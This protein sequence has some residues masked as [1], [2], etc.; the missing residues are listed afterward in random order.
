[1]KSV[2]TI[3]FNFY[4]GSA[5]VYNNEIHVLGGS[6]SAKVHYKWDGSSWVEVGTLPVNHYGVA[7]AVVYN[8]LCVNSRTAQ[9]NVLNH[10][11]IASINSFYYNCY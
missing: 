3:P 6:S 2:S 11:K 4:Y 1:M 9:T 10:L 8:N 7:K 5:V